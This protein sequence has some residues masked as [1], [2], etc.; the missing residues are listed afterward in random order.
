L[1]RLIV[2]PVSTWI[3]H[4]WISDFYFWFNYQNVYLFQFLT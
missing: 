4:I 2:V 3:C 1:R